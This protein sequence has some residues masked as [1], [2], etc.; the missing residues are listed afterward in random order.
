[1]SVKD[2]TIEQLKEKRWAIMNDNKPLPNGGW[3][4]TREEWD[5]ALALDEELTRRGYTGD[6]AP[7]GQELTAEEWNEATA[8]NEAIKNY[9]LK[10]GIS[11]KDAKN[12]VKP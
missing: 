3:G 5:Q 9:Q 7:K 11:S 12:K 6:R 1:M 10:I 4:L 2:L 8:V